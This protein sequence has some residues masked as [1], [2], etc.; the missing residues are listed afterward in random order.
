MESRPLTVTDFGDMKREGVSIAALTAYDAITAVLLD[1]AGVDLVLV[2][3]SLGTVYQG[4]GST[5]PV[6][7]EQMIYHGTIVSRVVS[8]ALVAVDMPFMTYQVSTEDAL[9]NAGLIMQKTGCSAVKLEGGLRTQKAIDG[10]VANGI[11]VIGHV[12]LTPQS[13][14]AFGGYGVRGR[15]DRQAILDDARAVEDAGAFAVVLEKMPRTLAREI[16][17]M[18]SIP[19]I[20]IGA[21]PHCDGQILVTEDMLGL[22]TAFK[23][24]FVRRY[25]ELAEAA[26]GGIAAYL[27]DVR[28]RSFPT[29][30]ESYD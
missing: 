23:P 26:R 28:D 17:E 16:T 8:H 9:R 29:D 18:L 2:G 27:S 22:F 25:A 20:G 19:T 12:G 14:H 24:A 7:L 4:H 21:G 30:E 13:V 15:D 11:P 1:E 6:T 3:D 10:V 5:V